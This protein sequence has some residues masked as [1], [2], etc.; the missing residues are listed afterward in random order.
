ML[1]ASELGGGFG[2]VA[3]MLPI[4]SAL[5][6]HGLTPLFAVPNPIEV[7]PLLSRTSFRCL[8]APRV[9]QRRRWQPERPQVVRSFADILTLAGFAEERVLWPM[10]EAWKTLLDLAD[11][12]L[13]VCE[14]SP[15]LCLA[16]IDRRVVVLGNGFTLPP[17]HLSDFP[18]LSDQ[19]HQ[20]ATAEMLRSVADVLRRRG[21]TV[22]PNLPS[23]L[24]GARHFVCTL[25]ELDP[26]LAW[27]QEPPC[28][29]PVLA[30]SCTRI[31][32]TVDLFA[33]LAGES[34]YSAP[35]IRALAQ[36]GLSGFLYARNAVP[37]LGE[38]LNGS[39]IQSLTDPASISSM[40]RQSRIV[41][42]HG[43]MSLA[44]EAVF[45]GR[46]QVLLP[47]YLEQYLTSKRLSEMG[48]AAVVSARA[49]S[50]EMA[51]QIRTAAA[52]ERATEAAC[53]ASDLVCSRHPSGSADLIADS[54]LALVV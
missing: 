16:A 29:P 52:S 48:L 15:F 33:Y 24:K 54:C 1:F 42:H 13:V 18:P 50:A 20:L 43:G 28:G 3:R 39:A 7:H 25:A 27:R 8:Q 32:P 44:E 38:L 19:P 40:L 35:I 41:V 9:E 4:A 37:E 36:S 11:P 51:Q 45:A 46:P 21:W 14:Y 53:R 12:C 23:M 2:H 17:P 47:I 34:P 6:E 22:P 26:Y 30:E 49:S 5:S 31:T 10:L